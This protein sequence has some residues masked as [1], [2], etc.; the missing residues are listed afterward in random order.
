MDQYYREIAARMN[1]T[2]DDD[3]IDRLKEIAG[4]HVVGFIK[5]R[6]SQNRSHRA[7]QKQPSEI[8]TFLQR[9]DCRQDLQ[10]SKLS[11]ACLFA[12]SIDIPLVKDDHFRYVDLPP[13]DDEG[14]SSGSAGCSQSSELHLTLSALLPS[15][16]STKE[17]T[18]KPTLPQ[19][20]FQLGRLHV[21]EVRA[22]STAIPLEPTYFVVVVDV[23]T[24]SK[25]LWL[26]YDYHPENNLGERSLV[27]LEEQEPVFPNVGRPF[28]AAQILPRIQ[29]WNDKL[30]VEAVESE[31]LRTRRIVEPRLTSATS[32]KVAGVLDAGWR[33]QR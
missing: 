7:P 17:I 10:L 9:L 33:G 19:Y 28:D 30:T 14:D 26:I 16:P 29:D 12:R 1:S 27:K 15:R 22:S 5:W 6:A 4:A 8:I 31:I 3:S 21:E 18:A 13:L 25:P 32:A 20:I 11:F 23:T 24:P 2:D